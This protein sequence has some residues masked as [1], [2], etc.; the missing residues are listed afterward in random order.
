M[1]YPRAI[2]LGSGA[3]LMSYCRAPALRTN[4]NSKKYEKNVNRTIKLIT[5]ILCIL[6]NPKFYDYGDRHEVH[7]KSQATVR[8]ALIQ[9]KANMI[10][11]TH[12]PPNTLHYNN[13]QR[14]NVQDYRAV[15]GNLKKIGPI[16]RNM[17]LLRQLYNFILS[18]VYEPIQIR[19]FPIYATWRRNPKHKYYQ[20]TYHNYCCGY[21]PA[22]S[23]PTN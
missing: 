17:Q 5:A 15:I 2:L 21:Y 6:R 10:H 8:R 19:E 18:S 12:E 7:L 11:H 22:E 1:H 16:P 20:P 4:W 3:R 23:E 9:N 13:V 14:A